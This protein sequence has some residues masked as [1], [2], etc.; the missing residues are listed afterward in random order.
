MARYIDID[1]V[2]P[3]FD[4]NTWQGDMM[5]SICENAK[6]EDVAPV[7][8][9]KWKTITEPFHDFGDD[10]VIRECSI[11]GCELTIHID[12]KTPYCPNCGAKMDS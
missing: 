11:C 12:Y 4:K 9:A 7:I 6:A 3:T 10:Y 1:K 5:I 8:H 2:I